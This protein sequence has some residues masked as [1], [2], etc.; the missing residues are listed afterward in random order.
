M[1]C[2]SAWHEKSKISYFNLDLIFFFVVHCSSP[3]RPVAAAASGF[4]CVVCCCSYW[5]TAQSTDIVYSMVYVSNIAEHKLHP[6]WLIFNF[7][8]Y[9][10]VPTMWTGEQRNTSAHCT[11]EHIGHVLFVIRVPTLWKAYAFVLCAPTHTHT[12]PRRQI[13]LNLNKLNCTFHC[14]AFPSLARSPNFIY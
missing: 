6:N 3:M 5:R 7:I 2:A 10:H 13:P 8:I 11:P 1:G 12:N 4:Q 14:S 9:F